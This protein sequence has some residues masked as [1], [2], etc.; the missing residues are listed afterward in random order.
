MAAIAYLRVSTDTQDI[1]KQR[2]E[3]HEYA[4]KHDFKI[5]EFVEVEMSSRKDPQARRI[6][7]LTGKL[8]AG[9][10]LVVSELSRLGRS[11]VEVINLVNGL[12]KKK[13]RVIAIKQNLDLKSNHDMQTKILVTLFSLLAELER[14]IISERTKTALRALKAGGKT[15]GRKPGTLGK[16]KLDGKEDQIRELLKHRV[17]KSAIARILGTSRQNLIN[18]MRSRRIK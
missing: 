4:R 1:N 15:L 9:D 10:I 8:K 12:L 6:E 18:F 5:K 11:L 16:S 14:D 13:V 3:I 17:A 2:L 7:E